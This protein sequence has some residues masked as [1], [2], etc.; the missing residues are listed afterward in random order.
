MGRGLY[1]LVRVSAEKE[2]GIEL[3]KAQVD[4]WVRGFYVFGRL[5][6]SPLGRRWALLRREVQKALTEE[7]L[8]LLVADVEQG[9][10][11]ARQLLSVLA[12]MIERGSFSPRVR[13]RFL[14]QLAG[15]DLQLPGP[16]ARSG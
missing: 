14:G 8:A 4:S 7:E 9:L 5:L 11:R 2:L 10:E 15:N 16:S 3:K 6:A 1:E 12:T 13:A